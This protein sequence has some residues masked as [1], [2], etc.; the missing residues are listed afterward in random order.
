MAEYSQ[1][2]ISGKAAVDAAWAL[3]HQHGAFIRAVIRFQAKNEFQEDDLYQQLFLSLVS[4]PMPPDVENVKSY[5]YRAI[6]NDIVD[7]A[8]QKARQ[9]KHFE[10]LAEEFRNSIHK[11]APADAF[12]GVGDGD[13]A[14]AC[15]TRHLRKREAQAVVMRYQDDRSISEIARV[16][17]VDRRT[18]SYYLAAALRQLR[19]ICAIE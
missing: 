1:N 13:A 2:G 15:L 4:R 11:E 3:F 18:V 12:L 17:G 14:L 16:M 19:R 6:A 8:R 5:L 10:K 7:T 9:R